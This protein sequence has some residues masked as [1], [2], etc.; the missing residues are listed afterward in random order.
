[1]I[2]ISSFHLHGIEPKLNCKY[3]KM[4]S[5]DEWTLDHIFQEVSLLC[6]FLWLYCQVFFRYLW[7]KFSLNS[8]FK[9]IIRVIVELKVILIR[10]YLVVTKIFRN[11]EK[12]LTLMNFLFSALFFSLAECFIWSNFF[13]SSNSQL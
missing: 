10:K 5:I 2:L 13:W 1:M 4:K 11:W 6:Y 8:M 3:L 7:H 12:V 9:L